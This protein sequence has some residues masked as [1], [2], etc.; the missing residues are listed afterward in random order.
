MWDFRLNVFFTNITG[1]RTLVT[2]YKLVS[3][4]VRLPTECFFTNITGIRTLVT[5]YKL[6]SLHVRLPTEC[7]FTNITG[8]RMLATMSKLVSLHVRLLTECFWCRIHP[9]FCWMGS[10][11]KSMTSQRKW[12]EPSQDGGYALPWQRYDNK[13][14]AM[15]YYGN[16]M[17]TTMS[18]HSDDLSSVMHDDCLHAGGPYKYISKK[19]ER[20]TTIWLCDGRT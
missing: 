10:Q 15:R 13:M 19:V 18:K 12:A 8:I 1:I 2:M 6:V 7:F 17:I 16:V 14:V 3:L 9:W 4:H 20:V 11:A 5:M